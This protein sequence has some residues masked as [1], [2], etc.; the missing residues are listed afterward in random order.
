MP[1]EPITRYSADCLIQARKVAMRAKLNTL[2]SNDANLDE[3]CIKI[4]V[5][6]IDSRS[7]DLT[8]EF[9]SRIKTRGLTG[10]ASN[11][12]PSASLMWRAKRIRG[13]DY[14]LTHPLVKNGF[15]EGEIKGWHEHFWTDEDGDNSIRVPN[16]QVK[17]RDMQY[18]VAWCC[19]NWNIEGIDLQMGLYP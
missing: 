12:W 7:L 9:Y 11:S 10:V 19:D 1:K 6:R 17:N 18:I 4:D 13:L 5:R 16:P 15:I 2:S 3:K 8:L 14:S